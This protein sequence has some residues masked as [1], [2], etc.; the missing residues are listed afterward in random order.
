MAT[1]EETTPATA[2]ETPAQPESTEAAPPSAAA[3]DGDTA[4]AD[5]P[6]VT[7]AGETAAAG[8]AAAAEEAPAAEPEPPAVIPRVVIV[9]GASSGLGLEV[10]RV[11]CDA[12]HDVVMAC[13]NE[14]KANR[15]IDK[16]KRQNMKGTLT[17]L[18]VRDLT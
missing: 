4:A 5:T 1:Q 15:A 13:R 3:G 6:P 18:H 11:L 12:G 16:L 14:E 17:Y 8:D 7:A 10:S 2:E 9:T